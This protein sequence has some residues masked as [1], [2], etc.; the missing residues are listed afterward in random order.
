MDTM[1]EWISFAAQ[2]PFHSN[3]VLVFLASIG[4]KV[5]NSGPQK[6]Q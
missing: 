5:P 3:S 4:L 2:A 1:T 6:F